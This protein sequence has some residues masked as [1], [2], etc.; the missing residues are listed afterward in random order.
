MIICTLLGFDFHLGC[1]IILLNLGEMGGWKQEKS[2]LKLSTDEAFTVTVTF[3][4]TVAEQSY[5]DITFA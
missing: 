5:S 3:K 1:F 2:I 4:L